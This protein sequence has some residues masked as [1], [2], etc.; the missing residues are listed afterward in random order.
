MEC[1]GDLIR[2]FQQVVGRDGCERGVLLGRQSAEPVSRLRGDHD[3]RAAS[4]DHLAEL[5]EHDRRS[6]QVDCQ[7]GF[8]WRLTR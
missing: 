1:V 6:V 3:A 2:L 4:S 5:L 7:D 8:G